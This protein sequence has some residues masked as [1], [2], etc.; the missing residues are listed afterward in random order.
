MHLLPLFPTQ[1]HDP[2]L[3]DEF[4]RRMDLEY[5]RIRDF[6]ILHYHLNCRDDAEL[7]RYCRAMD[8]PDSLT[9]KIRAVPALRHTSSSIATDCSRRRAGSA[10][11]SGRA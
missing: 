8:V 3:V 5:E 11:S 1:P 7:W 6:L 10:F 2:R 9:E 4:N